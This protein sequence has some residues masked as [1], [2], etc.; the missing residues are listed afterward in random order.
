MDE[1]TLQAVKAAGQIVFNRVLAWAAASGKWL[2]AWSHDGEVRKTACA[3]SVRALI[4]RGLAYSTVQLQFNQADGEQT[5]PT[6]V[7]AF[8]VARGQHATLMWAVAGIYE[9]ATMYTWDQPLLER[10][11]G[12][13]LGEA[14]EMSSG[15]FTRAYEG[16]TVVLDC[17]D[18]SATFAPP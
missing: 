4:E 11:F 1:A 15:V 13:A 16:G 12:V 2:S 14:V 7:A 8:L 5:L 17:N 10:D 18:F 6:S 3:T 9:S